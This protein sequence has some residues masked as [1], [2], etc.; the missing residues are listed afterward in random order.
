MT[1]TTLSRERDF[2]DQKEV[3][4]QILDAIADMVLV[5]G[6]GS[7]ILWANKAFRDY[8]GMTNEQLYERVDANFNQADYTEQYI[9]D[10]HDVYTSGQ[11]LN[12]PEEPVTRSDGLVQIFH[13]VKSPLRDDEGRVLMTVGVSRNITESKRAKEDLRRYREHLEH[14]VAERTDALSRLS[15]ELSTILSS[16]IEGIVAVDAG[17]RVRLVNPAA[18]ALLGFKEGEV[19]DKSIDEVIDFSPEHTGHDAAAAS[20]LATLLVNGQATTGQLRSRQG[21]LRLISIRAAPLKG[22]NETAADGMV[23]LLRDVALEREVADQRLRHQK[24]ESLG[25]LAGGIAHDFN[26]ILVGILANISAARIESSRGRAVGELLGQAEQACL[27]AQGLTGQLLTFA[28]GGAPIKK[29]LAVAKPVREAAE[30]TLRS[31]CCEFELS[32]ASDIAPVEADEGQLVQ[33]IG[34]LLM[35]ARQ[36][37][38]GGGRISIQVDNVAVKDSTGQL[39]LPPGPYVRIGV[40]DQGGGIAPEHLPR[41]FD[42]YFTTK[43]TGNG[44]GLASVHSIVKQHGGCVVVSSTPGAGAEFSVYLPASQ[45]KPAPADDAPA[46]E[47]SGRRLRVLVLDDDEGVREAIKFA[48]SLLGHECVVVGHSSSAFE[49][50]EAAQRDDVP[51]DAIFV[52]LT[53]PGDIGGNDV[54]AR[55][56]ERKTGA[57][58]IVMSGYSTD[59]VMANYQ[60][61]GLSARLQKPFTVTDIERVLG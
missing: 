53:M 54:I 1:N 34:N 41:I 44:L 14:L 17:G 40:L 48:L 21:D 3:Y 12:I 61:Y 15:N 38:P 18:E 5:K 59:L 32:V 29:T 26:N 56:V 50:V 36:A 47:R 25:L 2:L 30:F 6:A 46:R 49:W 55:L 4:R 27:R 39:P 51:F 23:L 7:R 37:M 19:V 60:E 20:S 13:T 24:L 28:R 42:P 57:K 22:A 10:D 16:L 43:P 58:L 31:S 11:V 35:N 9:R 52:D 8:Y 45:N 33:A